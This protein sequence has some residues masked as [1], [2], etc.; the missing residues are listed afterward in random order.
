[1]ARLPTFQPSIDD[2]L[3]FKISYLRAWGQLAHDGNNHSYQWSV[4]GEVI[5]TVNYHIKTVSSDRKE[6]I[7][8]YY[9]Q[10]EPIKYTV[11]IVAVVSNLGKGQRW[12][13]LCPHTNQRCMNLICPSGHK[14]FLHRL[15]YPDYLYDTQKKSKQYRRFQKTFGWLTEERKLMEQLNQPYRKT[16]YRGQPTPLFKKLIALKKSLPEKGRL[17][18][19]FDKNNLF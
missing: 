17:L 4:R 2:A 12:Y 16:H 14:Y 15:A 11:P 13:F 19:E 3:Q 7:F 9:Y 10:S 18:E 5:A 6:L 8:D 1:M